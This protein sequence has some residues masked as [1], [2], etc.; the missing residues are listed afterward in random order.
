[1]KKKSVAIVGGGERPDNLIQDMRSADIRIGVDYGAFWMIKNNIPVDIA[2]GD[3]DSVTKGELQKIHDGVDTYIRF[4]ADKDATDLELAV[5]EAIAL[6]A[7]HV[8]LYGVLGGRF[9][10]SMGAIQMLEKLVSHNIYG[11]IVDKSHK[12][13]IVRRQEKISRD[14]AFRYLS[15]IP[16]TTKAVV[17][18]RGC[19]YDVTKQSLFRTSSR[20]ISNEIV[21]PIATI[22]VHSGL[23]LVVRS[24]FDR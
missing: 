7:T 12:I 16:V 2:I 21:S 22:S 10:H 20:S 1:M 6:D 13:N 19:S 15:L 18:I 5:D 24:K 9:D 8:T 3:F 4:P 17:T 23:V 14:P 11:T